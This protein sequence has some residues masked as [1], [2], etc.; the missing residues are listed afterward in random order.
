MGWM[1]QELNLI[2]KEKML[3]DTEANTSQVQQ[4]RV[5]DWQKIRVSSHENQVFMDESGVNLALIRFYARF[6]R[7]QRAIGDHPQHQ[8]QNVS[9]VDMLTLQGPI[10]VMTLLGLMNELIFEAYVIHRG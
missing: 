10:A 2:R 6:P 8:G 3:H 9:I 1:L 4:A 5:D 7:S